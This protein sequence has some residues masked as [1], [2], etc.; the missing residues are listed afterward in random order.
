[1]ADFFNLNLAYA[2]SMETVVT[3]ST[4]W[5]ACHQTN[6]SEQPLIINVRANANTEYALNDSEAS[7]SLSTVL[8]VLI[9]H[10]PQW[11]NE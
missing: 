2:K 6:A 4:S 1:M 9:K 10:Q 11:H 5:I 7:L 3:I 8:K